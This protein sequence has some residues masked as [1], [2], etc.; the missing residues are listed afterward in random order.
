[1]KQIINKN[2]NIHNLKDLIKKPLAFIDKADRNYD[3]KSL[4]ICH[5]GKFLKLLNRNL[6][7][8][9]V[10]ERP[11]FILE[12]DN[13]NYIG[14]EHEVLIDYEAKKQEGAFEPG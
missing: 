4:E 9:K 6:Y 1:M 5:T 2:N 8:Y 3:K 10:G 11:D 7:I 13:Q 12:T 14:L